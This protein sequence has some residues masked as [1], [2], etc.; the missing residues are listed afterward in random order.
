MLRTMMISLTE[1]QVDKLREESE[2]LGLSVASII[3]IAV[4]RYFEREGA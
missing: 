4:S 1:E 2:K 3:R